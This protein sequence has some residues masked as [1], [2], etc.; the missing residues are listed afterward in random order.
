MCT[1]NVMLLSSVVLLWEKLSSCPFFFH[2]GED[3]QLSE[4][5]SDSD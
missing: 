3:L 5:G 1:T 4:S 2:S